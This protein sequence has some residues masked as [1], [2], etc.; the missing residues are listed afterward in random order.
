MKNKLVLEFPMNCAP[1][2]LFPFL[3]TPG[4]LSGWFADNVDVDA[5]FCTFFWEGSGQV[6]E[7]LYRKEN[8]FIRFRWVDETQEN[9]YFEFRIISDELTGDTSLIII[10]FCDDDEKKDITSLW[11]SQ[12]SVLKHCVGV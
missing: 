12:V 8:I 10:D 1:T 7:E 6:A 11:N 4:G 3:S 9:T 2:I 5:K